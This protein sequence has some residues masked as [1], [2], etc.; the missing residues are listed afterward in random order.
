M[1]CWKKIKAWR[2]RNI[3]GPKLTALDCLLG[4]LCDV[5]TTQFRVM[6]GILA[7]MRDVEWQI[8]PEAFSQANLITRLF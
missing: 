4:G 2:E 3:E 1:R 8:K 6:T 5:L 7:A